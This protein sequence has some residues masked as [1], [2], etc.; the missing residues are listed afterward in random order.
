MNQNQLVELF[1]TSV[2]NVC[3]HMAN[4]LKEMELDANSVIK[5]YL[6][7]AILFISRKTRNLQL[8][9]ATYV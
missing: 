2:Q 1:D 9:A 6:T 8:L 5:K 7:T 4:V 3:M